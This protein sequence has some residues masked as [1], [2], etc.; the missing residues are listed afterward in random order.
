MPH[1]K[2]DI[3]YI[4]PVAEVE[5]MI[6]RGSPRDQ[7]IVAVLYL[8][9]CRT[10]E[11]LRLEKD[12]IKDIDNAVFITLKTAKLGK[13]KSFT[14]NE[15]TLEFSKYAPFIDTVISYWAKRG[16]G[17]LL[18]IRQD[19]RVRQ[20]IYRLSNGKLCPYNFRHTRL[21]KLARNGATIDEL[22]YWKGAKS[23]RSVSEYI[24]N[25]PIGRRLIVD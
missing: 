24:R 14:I 9:G 13:S 19:S 3:N 4:V 15:R 1:Y 23:E 25:K 17:M 21:T 10:W 12:N 6:R 16:A 20:I 11:L 7:F 22:M 18:D 5:E 2:K 8:T